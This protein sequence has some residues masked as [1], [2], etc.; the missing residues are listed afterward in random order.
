MQYIMITDNK[1]IVKQS[2]AAKAIPHKGTEKLQSYLLTAL[3]R[4]LTIFFYT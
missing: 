2:E 3:M 4:Y 1:K